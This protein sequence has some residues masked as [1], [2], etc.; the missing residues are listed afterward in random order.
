MTVTRRRLLLGAIGLAAAVFGPFATSQ[1]LRTAERSPALLLADVAIG[2]SM[3]AA[4]LII[5]DRRPDNRIGALAILTGFVWFLGDFA[6]SD[7]AVVSYIGQVVHGWFD[8]LFALVILAYP[9]GRITRRIDRAL[10]IG[11][12]A[13]QAGW[14]LAKAYAMRPI[15]WWDCPT[16][17]STVDRWFVGYDA[18]DPLGRIETLLLTGLSLALLGVVV[19]RWRSAS[20]AARRRQTP[21][22][23]GG[24]VLAGGF[25]FEFLWQTI[26]PTSG[27]EP[28]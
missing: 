6:S 22:L 21:V 5:A 27:R 7:V 4:G 14:T 18:L 20:G 26:L 11:F 28:L 17:I 13:V 9:T 16:C 2:W 10:A 3:I 8:P 23:I 15:G 19:S 12:A 1:L 24:V 25:I